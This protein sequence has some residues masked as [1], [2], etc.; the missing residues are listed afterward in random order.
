[1][2]ETPMDASAGTHRV[3]LLGELQIYSPTGDAAD[4]PAERVLQRLLV[5]LALRA[6]QPR[7]T[8]EL[9]SILW[10]GP[11]AFS[12]DAKSLESP[13]SRLRKLGMPIP[14]R[15]GH[16]AYK[17]ELA[18]SDVD[19]LDFIDAVRANQLGLTE[20]GRLLALWRGDPR[21]VYGGFP[22]GEW[23]TLLRA[24]ERLCEHLARLS[25]DDIRQL[26]P[27]FDDF[28]E[29]F[30]NL[31]ADISLPVPR[32]AERRRCI[33]IVENEINVATMLASILT[34]YRTVIATSLAEAMEAVI[35]RLAE[36]DGALIDLHLTDRLDSAGL[37]VL[38]YIRDRRPDLP[39]LLITASPPP[40]SQ[41]HIR[42]TYG[43]VDTL[44]KGADGYS[45]SGVRDAVGLMFD[46]T[47]DAAR[48]RALARFESHAAQIRRDL[49][50]RVVA[51]S[52]GMR[53]GDQMAYDRLIANTGRMEAFEHECDEIRA[54]LSVTTAGEVDATVADY[55]RRWP[56]AAQPAG[57]G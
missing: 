18:R 13:A 34:D 3:N 9:I 45:A 28:A 10:P 7:H 4:V 46:E 30:P 40:G 41:E 43:I 5:A 25:P 8:D 33:F 47:D 15:R 16:D 50:Q 12:R 21:V 20:L 54:K 39:R 11:E 27:A 42:R 29:V 56:L 2:R 51:A 37:E 35:A 26:G 36:F 44:V 38:S 22:N 6:G 32:P 23:T 48:R 49:R 24:V 53:L 52:R 55:I 17:L 19:A 1:M 57:A 14:S 31:V